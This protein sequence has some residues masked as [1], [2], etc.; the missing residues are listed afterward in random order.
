MKL[1]CIILMD[2]RQ[3][4]VKAQR[5]AVRLQDGGARAQPVPPSRQ[6]ARRLLMVGDPNDPHMA[7]ET[8]LRSI[9]ELQGGGGAVCKTIPYWYAC[10]YTFLKGE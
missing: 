1:A 9:N 8:V 6:P 3:L 2:C 4:L 7:T 10:S 5:D